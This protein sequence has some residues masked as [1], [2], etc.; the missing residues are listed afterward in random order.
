M[1]IKLDCECCGCVN[2]IDSDN[3][4]SDCEYCYNCGNLLYIDNIDNNE[5][6]DLDFYHELSENLHYDPFDNDENC[7]NLDSLENE[8]YN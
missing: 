5:N 4:I 7:C 1:A 2:S 6:I 3:Y 8:C